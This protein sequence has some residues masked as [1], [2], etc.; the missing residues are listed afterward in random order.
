MTPLI[1][2]HA[3][4]HKHAIAPDPDA[5]EAVQAATLLYTAKGKAAATAAERE[6][7]RLHRTARTDAPDL[8]ADARTPYNL[9]RLTGLSL[10]DA[11]RSL[12]A[13]RKA[14]GLNPITGAR[15]PGPVP[16]RRVLP[17]YIPPPPLDPAD[18]IADYH[19][20]VGLDDSVRSRDLAAALKVTAKPAGRRY[21]RWC[22]E[23]GETPKD[24][25]C[26]QPRPWLDYALARRAEGYT[27]DEIARACGVPRTRIRDLARDLIQVIPL[28]RSP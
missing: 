12:G 8:F 9:A 10:P 22:A 21:A 25:P 28:R 24:S 18:P 1:S 6:L 15:S 4:C 14:R 11:E 2:Y 17:L 5:P 16:R 20:R 3:Y 19:R 27:C 23:Q 7:L 26:A 13:Y